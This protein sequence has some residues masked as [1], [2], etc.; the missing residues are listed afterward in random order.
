MRGFNSPQLAE[1]RVI[2]YVVR[3][4]LTV[5]GRVGVF[6]GKVWCFGVQAVRGRRFSK[7]TFEGAFSG[8]KIIIVQ[9]GLCIYCTDRK[10]VIQE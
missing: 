6:V 1:G 8:D 9:T 5:L 4:G 7:Q 3:G 2:H 10:K